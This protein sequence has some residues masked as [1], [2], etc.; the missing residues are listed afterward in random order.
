MKFE[1]PPA[2][3]ASA[4]DAQ[5][6]A[7]PAT[8][9]RLFEPCGLLALPSRLRL[10]EVLAEPGRP[11]ALFDGELRA[12]PLPAG[13]AGRAEV[14]ALVADGL[15]SQVMATSVASQP[16]G[17]VLPLLAD[18][19][20]PIETA[21]LAP[22]LV[23]ALAANGVT[24]WQSLAGWRLTEMARWARIGTSA[25]TALLH[26]SLHAASTA[27]PAPAA[28]I[29]PADLAV[30]LCHERSTGRSTLRDSLGR[31][32]GIAEPDEVQG[33]ARRLLTLAQPSVPVPVPSGSGS[34]LELV[35]AADGLLQQLGDARDRIVFERLCLGLG[36][37]DVPPAEVARALE[38]GAARVRKLRARAEDR[39]R[40]AFLAAPPLSAPVAQLRDELGVAAPRDAAAA[41]LARLGLPPA[42]DVR[43]A[44]HLWFAG[45]YRPFA[46][47]P[48]WLGVDGDGA[49]VTTRL[50]LG[51][52]GGV[53]RTELI[54]KELV[55]AGIAPGQ[56]DP[57]LAEQPVRVDDE[58]T[59]LVVGSPAA[60]A[61]RIL[62]ATGEAMTAAELV[63]WAGQGS[64]HQA[65]W[66]QAL[67]RDHRF[68]AV[69]DDRF[70]LAEWG[71]TTATSGTSNVPA[72]PAGPDGDEEMD[73][74]APGTWTVAVDE[75]LLS[76][77]SGPVPRSLLAQ[78][79]VAAGATRTIA[80]R[81]GPLALC[82]V[83]EGPRRGSLRPIALAAGAAAGDVLLLRFAPGATSAGVEV[84]AG[85]A[86]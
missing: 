84:V 1:G 21:G 62:A 69:A 20:G 14:A 36:S 2:G 17:E 80:T 23:A 41:A 49:R 52:D 50:L 72:G 74:P 28:L 56:V 60:V 12:L 76:G 9:G 77:G 33:A 47:L 29:E 15:P 75:D 39:A 45:P 27:I 78:L 16:L 5:L 71:G 19:P 46:G 53:H 48:G 54:R 86:T 42:G 13:A 57:W 44:L 30:L 35:A 61:E 34:G 51:E 40:Q 85:P 25:L 83:A 4:D 58:L 70:E 18:L 82:N 38:V 32:L 37:D 10:A 31:Y 67:R 73:Q 7:L 63:A 55:R 8:L 43:S 81:Y 3:D 26:A 6:L 64:G 66:R 11:L 22:S 59:V 65:S 79:G 68:V 24:S